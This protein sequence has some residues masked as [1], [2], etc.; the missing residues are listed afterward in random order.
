M[1]YAKL[2]SVLRGL[3]CQFPQDLTKAIQLPFVCAGT[4]ICDLRANG[5]AFLECLFEM[6]YGLAPRS[7]FLPVQGKP[8]GQVR[9]EDHA[10]HLQSQTLKSVLHSRGLQSAGGGID[11][12][13]RS[14]LEAFQSLVDGRFVKPDTCRRKQLHASISPFSRPAMVCNPC[15]HAGPHL[16]FVCH[17]AREGNS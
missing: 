11:K 9:V 10:R 14:D 3:L 8:R 6:F 13:I 2:Y 4:D 12:V 5:L 1:L 7:I 16:R 15:R 17:P